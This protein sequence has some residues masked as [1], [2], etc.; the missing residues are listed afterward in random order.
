M[1]REVRIASEG[2][3]KGQSEGCEGRPH[4]KGTGNE[5]E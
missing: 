2:D 3:E 4:N 1:W 5:R